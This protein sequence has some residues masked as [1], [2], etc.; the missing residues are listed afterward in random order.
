MKELNKLEHELIKRL[1]FELFV[2]EEL[3]IMYLEQLQSQSFPA[4]F[5][6]LPAPL[7]SQASLCSGISCS[8][9]CDEEKQNLRSSNAST[10]DT[11]TSSIHPVSSSNDLQSSPGGL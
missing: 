3:F 2:D 10:L 5:P 9:F 1:N 7:I 4:E 8:S 11:T 6:F